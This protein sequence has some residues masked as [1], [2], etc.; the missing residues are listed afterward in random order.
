MNTILIKHLQGKF[1]EGLFE[2]EA[3]S[4]KEYV[5]YHVYLKLRDIGYV[6][7]DSLDPEK[8][9]EFSVSD[10][11][12]KASRTC[13]GNEKIIGSIILDLIK[14]D[15]ISSIGFFCNNGYLII[16]EIGEF[17]NSAEILEM[18]KFVDNMEF[19]SLIKK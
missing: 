6:L 4:Q 9:N 15:H 2:V 8:S 1:V 3:T 5:N 7:I 10:T 11:I 16:N 17:R 12:P 14:S 18:P 13:I 19:T